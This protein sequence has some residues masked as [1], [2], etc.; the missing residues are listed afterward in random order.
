FKMSALNGA[1]AN[2]RL[3]GCTDILPVHVSTVPSLLRSRAIPV[4][5]ALIRVRPMPDGRMTTGSI[6]DYT[7]ALV[8]AARCVV[9]EIDER[10][11]MAGQDTG[12]PAEEIHYF[13]AA[14]PEEVLMPDPEPSATEHAVALEVAGIIPDGATVQLGVGTL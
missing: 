1:G 11:P 7:Q 8:G 5:V 13:T 10:L 14:G 2:R 4:D 12:L 9:A 6:A 3:S